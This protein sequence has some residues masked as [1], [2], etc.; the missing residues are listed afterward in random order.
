MGYVLWGL[1]LRFQGFA[2]DWCLW[3]CGVISGVLGGCV[4]GRVWVVGLLGVDVEL[5]LFGRYFVLLA[6]SL[7]V[8]SGAFFSWYVANLVV[9]FVVSG[10][11]SWCLCFL[12]FG[13]GF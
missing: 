13:F 4:G 9:C 1:V 12:G 7:V 2:L 5:V 6:V 3:C 10:V 8:T 11:Y